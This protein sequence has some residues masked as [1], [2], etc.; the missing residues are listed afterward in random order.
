MRELQSVLSWHISASLQEPYAELTVALRISREI[1]CA[2]V[3]QSGLSLGPVLVPP[4][5]SIHLRLNNDKAARTQTA[6][7]DFKREG[8]IG[9]QDHGAVVKFR[10]VGMTPL[11]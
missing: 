6:L 1:A 3:F 9:L 11:D 8:H 4:T 5:A 2:A 7:K 10:N